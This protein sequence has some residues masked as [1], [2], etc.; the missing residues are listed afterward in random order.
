MYGFVWWISQSCFY[1]VENR[2]HVSVYRSYLTH[3]TATY[4]TSGVSPHGQRIS[5]QDSI[6]VPANQ[7]IREEIAKMGERASG[8]PR[9]RASGRAL[10]GPWGPLGATNLSHMGR[11]IPSG[12]LIFFG[13]V[14]RNHQ[15]NVNP[16]MIQDVLISV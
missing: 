7:V 5:S 14:A 4:P 13:G 15:M 16:E 3:L 11:V 12:E 1:L 8:D 6:Q 10:Q 9:E 2:T